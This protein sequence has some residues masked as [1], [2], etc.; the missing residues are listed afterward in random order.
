MRIDLTKNFKGSIANRQKALSNLMLA[1]QEKN[2]EEKVMDSRE[3]KPWD[4]K[5]FFND[6]H[7][8]NDSNEEMILDDEF[9]SY[10]ELDSVYDWR[11]EN[12]LRRS[13]RPSHSMELGEEET[14]M[15]R[16]NTISNNQDRVLNMMGGEDDDTPGRWEKRIPVQY[17]QFD[18]MIIQDCIISGSQISV[19][20]PTRIGTCSIP[21]MYQVDKIALYAKTTLKEAEIV[22]KIYRILEIDFKA[23]LRF[24]KF[25]AKRVGIKPWDVVVNKNGMTLLKLAQE[26]KAIALEPQ[27]DPEW[28]H[29]D[30]GSWSSRVMDSSSADYEAGF[31]G[32]DWDTHRLNQWDVKNPVPEMTVWSVNNIPVAKHLTGS[33]SQEFRKIL[34]SLENFELSNQAIKLESDKI[35][36]SGTPSQKSKWTEAVRRVARIRCLQTELNKPVRIIKSALQEAV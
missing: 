13:V 24:N 35:K 29:C 2:P 4:K 30:N 9:E 17:G 26:L 33:K 19:M 5:A 18:R 1:Y 32:K 11:I 23:A 10:H 12:K 22:S 14:N 36:K 3:L 21:S 28:A 20:Q 7:L 25:I 16:A 6:N 27:E 8:F 15:A 34:S 31:S